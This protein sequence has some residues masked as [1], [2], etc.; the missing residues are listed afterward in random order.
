MITRDMKLC[1]SFTNSPL[2][3]ELKEKELL[4]KQKASYFASKCLRSIRSFEPDVHEHGI[5][6][7]AVHQI[8]LEGVEGARVNNLIHDGKQGYA[9]TPQR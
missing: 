2:L 8:G 6:H 7:H 3:V 1:R 5:S 4:N 9:A